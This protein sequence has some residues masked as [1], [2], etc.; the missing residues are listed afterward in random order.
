MTFISS[1][2]L[3]LRLILT[4]L[5]P[6][7]IAVSEIEY[8]EDQKTLQITHK[9]FIDNLENHI[10]K[11]NKDKGENVV[12]KL[13]TKWENPEANTIIAKYLEGLFKIKV[14]GKE[15]PATF[16]GKEYETDA[17]WI[18]REI[19]GIKNLKTIEITDN[20]L[21]DYY[22]DQDNL[23]HFS[24]GSFKKSLRFNKGSR[25]GKISFVDSQKKL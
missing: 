22:E 4:P 24:S 1:L 15:L 5:H 13:N 17:V 8:K 2:L 21:M 19:T 14:N 9:I 7:H 10:E 23:L 3:T 12:L 18:Y 6:I 11:M 20:I 16:L 25:E